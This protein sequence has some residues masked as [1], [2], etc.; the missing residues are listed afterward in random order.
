[1]LMIDKTFEVITEESAENGESSDSGYS[2]INERVSFRE[3]VN[4][5]AEKYIYPSQRPVAKNTHVWFTSE[6]DQDYC[7]G[8]Y[9]SESIHFSRDNPPFKAKYWIKA[10]VFARHL[11]DRRLAA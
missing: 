7:T 2:A 9:R 8:D 5:M 3:L 10:M 1:M 6:A 4:L 11:R